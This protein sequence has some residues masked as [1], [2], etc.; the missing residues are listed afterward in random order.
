MRAVFLVITAVLVSLILSFFLQI[1]IVQAGEPGPFIS[2]VVS[3][4]ESKLLPQALPTATDLE[5]GDLSVAPIAIPDARL[6]ELSAKD[7]QSILRA[8]TRVELEELD[9][10]L[11]ADA[12]KRDEEGF[13]TD[14]KLNSVF[15]LLGICLPYLA[16]AIRKL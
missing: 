16:I 14:V 12:R 7:F 10:R 13:W 11:Q 5:S 2:R 6:V 8:A 4:I 9:K 3:A 1:L 15:M